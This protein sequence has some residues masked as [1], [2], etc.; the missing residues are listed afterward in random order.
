MKRLLL[1]TTFSLVATLANAH[2]ET[3]HLD[4]IVSGLAHP[5]GGLDHVLAMTGV[6]LLG[7]VLGG[8]FR[9]LMPTAFVLMMIFGGV[10]ALVGIRLPATEIAIILSVTMIGSMIFASGRISA[11]K[12]LVAAGIFAVFHGHAHV[13][14]MPIGSN[15][16]GYTAGFL[17]MTGL[18]HALGLVLA[19]KA[20]S[21]GGRP[22]LKAAGAVIAGTG[23]SILAGLF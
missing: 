23:F 12:A 18:L 3:S 22:V 13:A 16:A 20:A 15:L 1:T 9:W 2:P 10:L 21:F 14:E 6:G 11:G 17:L 7:Y 5:I 19:A 8:C 4:G